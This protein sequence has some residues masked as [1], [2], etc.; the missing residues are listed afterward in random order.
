[1][2]TVCG[3][4]G[5]ARSN[6]AERAAG[7][8]PKRRGRPPLPEDGLLADIKAVIADMP[9]Y[10][11]G[12]VWAVLRRQAIAEGRQ[13]VN[14][15]RVYRVM[16]VH[17]LLLRQHAGSHEER[18][19]DGKIA[20]AQ[21]NLRWCSDGF[22]IACDNAEKVRVAFALDCCDREAMGHV[23][24]TEGIKGE[25]VRD[26]MV[27]AVEQRFGRVNHLP[28]IIEWL[29]DNGSCYTAIET[30]N[31]AK[32]IGF[33]PLTTPVESPQSNG[34]AEAFVRT[35]K[36]DYVAVNPKPDATTV[37]RSL[38]K[39]FEHYN[40]LHPHRTLGYLSPRE[41]IAKMSTEKSVDP[42]SGI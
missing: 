4:I 11:Y 19:H 30:R 12:R 22:E 13:P 2:K 9:S 18:R 17:G 25:D 21:S 33:L 29:S 41:F 28:T 31:F 35:F 20:V 42:V 5:V 8:T 23:A 34:M 16:R 37:I 32:D 3:T 26:L 36:R 27:T 7:R 15:K 39:W 10:G 1:M 24:T 40:Q 14:R 6:V 38:P